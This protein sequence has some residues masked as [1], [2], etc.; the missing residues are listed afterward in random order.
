M[1]TRLFKHFGWKEFWENEK[2]VAR[3]VILFIR[4]LWRKMH[5]DD[6]LLLASAI[7][8]NVLLCLLPILLL[9]IY[10]LGLW[11]QSEEAIRFVDRLIAIAFPQ[12]SEALELRKTIS[13]IL[14][15]IVANRGRLGVLSLLLLVAASAS[16]FTSTRSVLHR[17]FNIT[18][19]RHFLV[20]YLADLSLVLALTLL[21]VL[22]TSVS[23]IYRTI[24]HLQEMLPIDPSL[25]F[26]SLLGMIPDFLSLLIVLFLCF[27]LYRYVPAERIGSRTAFVSAATTSLIWEISARL[28]AWYLSTLTPL[29]KLYGTYAFI[30]VLLLWTFYSSLIFVIG[31]EVGQV[32]RPHLKKHRTV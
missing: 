13:S 10:I 4:R 21:I 19:P 30:V 3:V 32:S 8:F 1:K 20:S 17:V 22:T 2:M 23:W 9:W 29:S 5:Q 16:L 31:A 12:Q 28:F 11:L 24:R 26:L 14:E 25:N 7:A 18:R 6:I 27:L 15:G